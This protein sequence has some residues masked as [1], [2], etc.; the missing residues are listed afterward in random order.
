MMSHVPKDAAQLVLGGHKRLPGTFW[1]V[2]ALVISG[3][4]LV[5]SI[6]HDE[7]QYVAVIALMRDGLP[8]RDFA[9]L[10]TPLQPLILSPLSHLPAGSVLIAARAAN[11]TFGF[12]TLVL[13]S[14]ALRRRASLSA[15]IA[16]LAALVCTGAFLLATSLARNDALAMVL[17]AAALPPLL[18]AT[19]T[20]SARLFAAG[21]VALGLALSAKINAALPA[22]GA[23]LFM[24]IRARQ[25]GARSVLAFCAGFIA[26][27]LPMLIMAGVAPT[28]FRFDVFDYNLEAPRQW[29]T[30]ISEAGELDPLRRAI[31]LVGFAA[32][33]SVLVALIAIG[34][35]RTRT[36]ARRMLEFMI[37]GGVVGAF[38][39]VPAL[40][41]Y[42][43]PLL[44]P[45]FVRFA[46]GLD[47]A[48]PTHR[49][50]LLV[51]TVVGS[52]AGLAS[53]FVVRSAAMDLLR[54]AAVGQKVAAIAHGGTVVTLAPEYVAG[55]G[56]LLD[57][58]FAAGPFLYRTRAQL[59]RR[60]EEQGRAVT[61]E[62]LDQ[63]LAA[64]PPAV[65]VIGAE[66]T[67]F[68]PNF[69]RGLDGPLAAWAT[70]HGYRPRT[71][72]SGLVA[73]VR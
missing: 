41:Q 67:A 59:A 55:D 17:L 27:L 56:V 49:N 22:A 53:D 28:E 33:G 52:I 8:Y 13:L 73:F 14:V 51:L 34:L 9:Y 63:A 23:F 26:G 66:R 20:R 42:L 2:L 35:D 62:T 71:V 37:G 4:A 47:G 40:V 1:L 10:Q 65:I 24:V 43:V 7:S 12:A 36:D 25:F 46:L 50:V 61:S 32:L 29:W 69:P 38:L 57:P 64:D 31:K 18:T 16:A 3:S 30:S 48:R 72:G 15:R 45:L 6:N 19:E 5:R 60:A 54:T 21:G 39:P 44:P 70:A 11:V 58:R 68:L